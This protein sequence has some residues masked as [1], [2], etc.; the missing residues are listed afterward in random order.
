[1]NIGG[2]SITSMVYIQIR[3]CTRARKLRACGAARCGALPCGACSA[4]R[5]GAVR[6]IDNY[7]L[8]YHNLF[9]YSVLPYRDT[10]N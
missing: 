4:V 10:L 5:C 8:L 7:S 3:V 2:F 1:M 9:S 6:C